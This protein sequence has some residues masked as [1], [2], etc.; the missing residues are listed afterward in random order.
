LDGVPGEC[1]QEYSTFGRAGLQARNGEP[2]GR[3]CNS[4]RLGHQP[5]QNDRR[6]VANAGGT[7]CKRV[8]PTVCRHAGGL[9]SFARML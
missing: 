6:R 1:L 9:Q 8:S 4:R 3:S 7:T 2:V 5:Q